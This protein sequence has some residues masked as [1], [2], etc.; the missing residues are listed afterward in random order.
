V[1]ACAP[2]FAPHFVV[3]T[4]QMRAVLLPLA[5]VFTLPPRFNN[6]LRAVAEEALRTTAAHSVMS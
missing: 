1:A 3:D 6:C 5:V 2:I 4:Q